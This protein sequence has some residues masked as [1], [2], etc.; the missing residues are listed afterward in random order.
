MH[1]N[2]FLQVAEPL[3]N[4][5]IGTYIIPGLLALAD[6]RFYPKPWKENQI[7]MDMPTWILTMNGKS[8][9]PDPCIL[10]ILAKQNVEKA[11][12][13]ALEWNSI[14]IHQGHTYLWPYPN[15]K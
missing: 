13:I 1:W 7:F 3:P 10:L 8:F 15:C 5:G 9:N 12:P 14:L 6:P 4:M 2:Q 11:S